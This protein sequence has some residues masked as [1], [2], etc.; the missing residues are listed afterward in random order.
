VDITIIDRNNH[1]LFQ[2]L[3]YQVATGILSERDIAPPIRDI[4]RNQ[5]N[6]TVLLGE[7]KGIDL[8]HRHLS[9]DTLGQH[10]E[11]PYDSLIVATGASQSY[12]GHPEFAR[13]ALGMKTIDNGLELRSRIF[14]AFEMAEREPEAGVRNAWLTFVVVGAGPTGVELAGQIAELARRSLHHN[15][16]RI[17]PSTARVVL[18]DAGPTILAAFPEELQR[19]TTRTLE[20]MG[21]EIRLGT[22]VTGVDQRGIDTSA[23]DPQFKR[24]D[25]ATK[26]WAAGVEAS[27]LGRIVARAAGA[28]V[29]RAGRVQ[30]RRDCTLPR[31]PR[32]LRNRRSNKP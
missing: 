12:F 18:L 13:H 15:F 1:H 7:V 29:D 16:R 21:V 19:R 14:G 26:I 27:P 22:T 8:Q 6:A 31:T 2:P 10:S 5:R 4:L 23:N 30:V 32:G 25:A 3:L 28:E 24:L 9:V 11:V 17:D 20:G